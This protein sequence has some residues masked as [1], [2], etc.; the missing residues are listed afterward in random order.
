MVTAGRSG[1]CAASGLG[2][3]CPSGLHWLQWRAEDVDG[4][5]RKWA[6]E[7]AQSCKEVKTLVVGEMGEYFCGASNFGP[8]WRWPEL[9]GAW[10]GS[11]LTACRLKYGCK[12]YEVPLSAHATTLGG[13]RSRI[14]TPFGDRLRSKWSHHCGGLPRASAGAVL[15]RC[16]G[17]WWLEMCRDLGS[18]PRRR[19]TYGPSTAPRQSG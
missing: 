17:N 14:P 9:L 16:G 3:S 13:R 19:T 12:S 11:D 15:R 10:A 5:G 1:A 18:R 4:G 6:E 8:I 7:A 2:W